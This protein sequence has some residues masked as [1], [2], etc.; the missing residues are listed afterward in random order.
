MRLLLSICLSAGTAIF[1][2]AQKPNVHKGKIEYIPSFSS[3]I[4]DARSVAIWTPEN[5]SPSEKGAYNVLYMHDGQNVFDASITWNHQSWEVA[6]HL[7]SLIDAKAI[8]PCIVVAI[9]NNGEKRHAEY[10]PQKPFENINLGFRD[11]LLTALRKDSESPLFKCAPYSDD[12]LKFLVTE[13]KPYVDQHYNT[14]KDARH[15]FVAGASMGGLISW[16]AV[17]RYPEVFG[18]A[19]CF[20]THWPGIWPE[21]DSKKVIFTAFKEYFLQHFSASHRFYF[22]HGNETLDQYYLPYQSDIDQNVA[23]KF[24]SAHYLSLYYPGF[25]HSEKSWS[26]H[27]EKAMVFLMN[28]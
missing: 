2:W 14:Y 16:Y 23:Q 4:V 8:P 25:D 11:S 17:E 13:V 28:P 24:P 22:D 15:T 5:Y 19:G 9:W 18:G 21:D 6:D 20:S 7:Q 26:H 3:Q 1:S 12:Y 10:F 27:F